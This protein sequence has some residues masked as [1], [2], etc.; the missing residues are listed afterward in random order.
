LTGVH[1][2][3]GVRYF[4]KESFESLLW[5]MGLPV[6][7]DLAARSAP[8]PEAIRTLGREVAARAGAA[9]AAGYRLDG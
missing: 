7:L 4:V 8:D 2:E 9:A 1:E 3:A 5:W 6:L